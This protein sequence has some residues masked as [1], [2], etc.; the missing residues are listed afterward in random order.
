MPGLVLCTFFTASSRRRAWSLRKRDRLAV[1]QLIKGQIWDSNKLSHS[2]ALLFPLDHTIS[3]QTCKHRGMAT[4]SISY[5]ASDHILPNQ[6][7][8]LKIWFPGKALFC[9][10]FF[11]AVADTHPLFLP[12]L[13]LF[14]VFLIAPEW[15]SSLQV[16][17]PTFKYVL[18][19]TSSVMFPI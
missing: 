18:F 17:C 4:N 9:V 13:S 16:L 12:E 15:F 3:V 7:G 14:S 10:S 8:P 6:D 11:P 1:T 19:H 2:R 5:W